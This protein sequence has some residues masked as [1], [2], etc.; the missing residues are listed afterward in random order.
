[1]LKRLLLCLILLVT[2][3]PTLAV[4][5][6]DIY[7]VL[8]EDGYGF[9]VVQNDNPTNNFLFITFFIYGQNK[10]PTWYTAQLTDD[11]TGKTYAGGLYATT[12]TYFGLPWNPSDHPPAVQVG[13]ASFQPTSPYTATFMYVVN[14][15]PMVM[16]N[17]SIQRQFLGRFTIG[18]TYNGVA[19][20]TYSACANPG[21]F[22]NDVD[23]SITQHTD[24]NQVSITLTYVGGGTVCTYSGDAI[25]WGKLYQIPTASYT[26]TNGFK[27]TAKIDELIAT[28]HG[29]EGVWSDITPAGCQ[30]SG[31]FSGLLSLP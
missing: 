23:I 17:K 13:T 3:S 29:I 9:N 14:G 11:G 24:N 21:K 28:P 15:P 30:E 27:T 5:Y 6:T 12:G 18:G 22:L 4:D 8:G 20:T 7:Y 1:M 25:A 10:Q 2:A 16:V 26:C 19:T 31:T